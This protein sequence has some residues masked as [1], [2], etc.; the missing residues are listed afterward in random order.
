M[1]EGTR[2]GYNERVATPP[3]VLKLKAFARWQA[4]ERLLDSALCKA[5]RE[6]ASGLV[7]ADLGGHLYK[8]RVARQ[9]FGKS[10]GYRTILAAKIDERYV[11]LL[12]F[13]KNERD[14][15]SRPETAALQV[16][17]RIYLGL[18]SEAL[19]LVIAAGEL[20]EVCCEQDH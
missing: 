1:A 3:V 6:I 13:A 15:I 16:Q 4:N 5:A 10:G 8:K 17:A 14:N 11:F 12:G 18:S 9:G 20:K 7:D 19:A 2:Y